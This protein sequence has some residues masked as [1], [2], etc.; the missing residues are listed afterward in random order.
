VA[1]GTF[2]PVRDRK[3]AAACALVLLGA[4]AE[5]DPTP[6]VPPP[7]C[8]NF[9]V[10]DVS[11]ICQSQVCEGKEYLCAVSPCGGYVWRAV[12]PVLLSCDDGDPCHT[13]GTCVGRACV[14]APLL[15]ASPPPAECRDSSTLRR[16][17]TQGQCTQGQCQYMPVDTSCPQGCSN[18]QCT[19]DPC[20]GVVC[21]KPPS[22]CYSKPGLCAA[23]QCSYAKSAPMDPCSTPDLCAPSGTCDGNGSCV[24]VPLACGAP[25]ADGTCI[26]GVCLRTCKPGFAD[27]DGDLLRSP[28]NGC[29]VSTTN[30]SSHCGGCGVVCG[31]CKVCSGISCVVSADGTPV[32]GQLASRRC[33]KGLMVDIARDA[34]NC[35]GCGLACAAGK[36]CEGVGQTTECAYAPKETSGR[37]RC[38][39]DSQC[40]LQQNCRTDAPV[41]GRCSA[42]SDSQCR[43]G[44]SRWVP[45]DPAKADCPRFCYYP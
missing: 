21:D 38:T 17:L 40:P 8:T 32:A 29:E 36:D 10:C 24:A 44:E 5:G 23:G 45:P 2:E 11:R 37:C 34:A 20:L 31:T 35:G 13:Q 1:C 4:C 39:T 16:Y 12:G 22:S 3:A 14:S 28:S 30:N 9:P 18:A 27:C 33:C 41:T 7:A 42:T 6:C 43:P 25:N 19:N 15:C 26:N